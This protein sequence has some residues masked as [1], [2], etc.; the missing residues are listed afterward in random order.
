MKKGLFLIVTLLGVCTLFL[1]HASADYF[2]NTLTITA[3]DLNGTN[4]KPD[5]PVAFNPDGTLLASYSVGGDVVLWNTTT[6]APVKILE[7]DQDVARVEG[8]MDIVFSKDGTEIAAG[9]LNG[10]IYIWNVADGTRDDFDH[11]H[12]VLGVAFGHHLIKQGTD[13]E[14]GF[15]S[16]G[17]NSLKRWKRANGKL[18]TSEDIAPPAIAMVATPE[19]EDKFSEK[20]IMIGKTDGSLDIRLAYN[21]EELAESNAIDSQVM[22][23]AFVEKHAFLSGHL[24]GDLG[25]WDASITDST[26]V[27]HSMWKLSERLDSETKTLELVKQETLHSG[28]VLSLEDLGE[29]WRL[30]SGSTDGEIRIWDLKLVFGVERTLTSAAPTQ[31]DTIDTLPDSD[32]SDSKKP[33]VLSLDWKGHRLACFSHII[34]MSSSISDRTIS[35]WENR[36][37]DKDGDLDRDDLIEVVRYYGFRASEGEQRYHADVDGDNDVDIEDFALM[38][39]AWDKERGA[40]APAL[41]SQ[42]LSP[43]PFSSEKVQQMLHDARHVQADAR[44]IAILEQFLKETMQQASAPPPAETSLFANYPNPFNPETWIPY[45]LA[46]KAEV[47]VYIYTGDGKRV[48]TLALGHQAPGAYQTRSRAAYWDGRNEHGE[49]VA[50][51]V[52][53]YT[54]KV[55]GDFTATRKMLILK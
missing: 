15:I 35:I 49:P 33:Q 28:A 21:F 45:Q 6:G 44:V 34:A 10:K 37:A 12:H 39:T 2:V 7:T 52:Y 27:R 8:I 29:D 1:G 54:L 38:A 41:E 40:G 11:E 53:F 48:R 31:M 4:I 47:T 5:F 50:S 13:I 23:L 3:G 46:T 19:G 36:D 18:L 25:I 55:S 22:A 30:A 24:N 14:A 43:F 32:T 42:R 17:L 26:G 20:R 51:G 9:D 16:L